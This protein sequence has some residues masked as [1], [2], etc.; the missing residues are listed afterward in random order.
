MDGQLK[1]PITLEMPLPAKRG[2]P[3]KSAAVYSDGVL[4]LSSDERTRI[5]ELVTGISAD[6]GKIQ[7]L[8][9]ST[10]QRYFELGGIIFEAIRRAPA[11]SAVTT[12]LVEQWTQIPARKVTTALKVYKHFKEKPELLEQLTMKDLTRMIGDDGRTESGE[13]GKKVQY[14]L[15]DGPSLFNNDDF[16]MPTL[17]GIEL[18]TF[19]LRMDRSRGDMYL[20]KKGWNMPI[21]VVNF[22]VEQPKTPDVATAYA[23]LFDETQAALE[24]YYAVIEQAE[25]RKREAEDA[26]LA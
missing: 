8:M 17:S 6:T 10:A 21:Q 25:K 20:L 24:R 16:G 13:K 14:A 3:S 22:T 23:K 15:S 12:K 5:N 26:A 2:R 7:R 18:D 4:V 19:R 9:I 11:S 1:N